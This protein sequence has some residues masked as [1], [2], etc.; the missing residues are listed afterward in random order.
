MQVLIVE[1]KRSLAGHLGRALEGEGYSVTLAY[2][3]EE[4]LRLGRTNEFD[5]MLL[6]VMLPRMDG[7]TVIRKLREAR[8]RTQ[9]II[10]S[11]R[12]SMDD[13]VCGLDAGADDY[14]TKPFA[15]DVLLARIRAAARRVPAPEPRALEFEDLI[16]RP[17]E[18][19]LQ[20][21]QRVA[22]LTRTECALLAVLMRRANSIVPHGVLIDEGWSSD[23]D[24]SFDSL[25]VFIRALRSKITHPGEPELL[26]TVRGIGYSLRSAACA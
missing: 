12:D 9:A 20:R 22:S 21:G 13:I 6:D 4:A 25:Y 18:H 26:H 17:R 11:A 3:G 2:D 1:D 5:V 7:V 14:L 15:L 16:L 19:E 23:A 24:V 10:V 8:L